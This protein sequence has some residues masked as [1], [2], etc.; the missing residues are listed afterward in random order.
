MSELIRNPEVMKKAQEEVRRVYE[1]KGMINESKF[2]ELE[3]LKLVIKESLRLHP[4]AP[5][6]LPRE[7]IEKGY[8]N[9][10][11]IP[12]KTRI[13]V[14]AWA[15]QRDP[16]LWKDPETFNP[17]RFADVNVDMKGTDFVYLP[18]GTGRR[19]CPGVAFGLSN[20]ELPIASLLYHFDWSLPD[21]VSPQELD[22]TEVLGSVV[23]RKNGLTLIPKVHPCSSI[24]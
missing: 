2:D 6:L 14:N 19:M 13:L 24:P 16:A 22:M 23:K 12:A 15:I 7:S 1:G 18:F 8:I 21:G 17:E 4:L 10:Y 20:V 11:E 9:G 5:M 3:Y